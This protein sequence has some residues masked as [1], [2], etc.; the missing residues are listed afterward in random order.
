MEATKSYSVN[1]LSFSH[2][3]VE[4][5]FAFSFEKQEGFSPILISELPRE[6]ADAIHYPDGFTS[7]LIYVDFTGN[8]KSN[9]KIIVNF[10]KSANFAKRYYLF[11]ISE[12][13]KGKAYLT[14]YNFIGD[15]VLYFRDTN[16]STR[17]YAS[18]DK[19]TIKCQIARITTNPEILI[20]YS[21]TSKVLLKN[22][23]QLNSGTKNINYVVYDKQI[24]KYSYLAQN[25]R[26]NLEHVF[27]LLNNSLISELKISLTKRKSENKYLYYFN[28]IS[29]LLKQYINKE[30][31]KQLIPIT[32]DNFINLPSENIFQLPA[33]SRN[34]VFQEDK[35]GISPKYDIYNK[36]PFSSSPHSKIEIFLLYHSEYHEYAL[37][38]E[39]YF[40][41]SVGNWK[42]MKNFS[43]LSY[44]L[45]INNSIVFS[46]LNDP[47]PEIIDK[48][49]KFHR[50]P[51]T[52]YLCIYI[53]PFSKDDTI[54]LN[55]SFYYKIKYQLLFRNIVC[56]AI[57]KET[58]D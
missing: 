19:F 40:N 21:G 18:F 6:S 25:C 7:N 29:W 45:D 10:A 23:L 34:L 11:Q 35:I 33:S 8:E 41:N 15:L 36:G 54:V 51:D 17:Q 53:T 1:V 31:F 38:I 16:E 56:Q 42:G 12:Y 58:F 57:K 30:E 24:F 50:K 55:Q 2:P 52:N 9:N 44:S 22:V 20:S 49:N 5:Q 47:M 43:N 28:K 32:T 37:Q 48:L 26:P 14:E 39:N 3:I 46:Y 27:P 4:K 13:F